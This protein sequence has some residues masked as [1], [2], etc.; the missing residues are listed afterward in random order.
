M[1]K[2]QL[3]NPKGSEQIYQSM[4]F[5]QAIKYNNTIW[6][7]GQVGIDENFKVGKGIEEQTQMAFQNLEKVL[8]EAGSGMED[9]IELVTYHTSMKEIGRFSKIKTKF[10][11]KNYPAWTAVGVTELVLPDL[12]VEIRATAIGK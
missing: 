7:S 12:L 2:K 4:Q 9:I 6:I 10:I 3:I 8:N 11:P 1:I 5:S